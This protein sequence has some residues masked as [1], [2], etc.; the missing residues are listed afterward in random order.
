MNAKYHIE[1]C[2][3]TR[4]QTEGQTNVADANG[5]TICYHC[6]SN[7]TDKSAHLLTVTNDKK[8]YTVQKP[9]IFMPLII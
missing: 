1:N 5:I 7:G 4:G 9:V 8:H 3:R 2:D 6:Y